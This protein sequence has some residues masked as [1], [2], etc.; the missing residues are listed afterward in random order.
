MYK[1]LSVRLRKMYK[2]ILEFLTTIIYIN[3]YNKY[4]LK[5]VFIQ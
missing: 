3:E 4:V 1:E 2:K 5:I